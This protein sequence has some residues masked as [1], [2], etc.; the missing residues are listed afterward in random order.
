VNLSEALAYLDAHI[1]LEVLPQGDPGVAR[2]LDRMRSLVAALGDPQRAYPVLHLTGTNGKGSTARMLTTLLVARGLSVGTYTSPHLE[3]VNERLSWNDEAISDGAFAEVV[4]A[5]SLAERSLDD[6]PSYFELLTAAGFRWFDDIAVD[7]AVVEV[8]LGGRWDA[9]NVADAD[10]AVVTNVEMDHTEYLGPDRASIADVKA[11]IVKPGSRLVLGETDPDLAAP[12]LAAEPEE[13]WLRGR[14]FECVDNRLAHGGRL[15]VLRTP[16][17]FVHDIFLPLHG[18]H[19]GDN[20]AAALAASELFFGGPLAEEAVQEA[21]AA[22][23][24]PGRMEVVGRRPLVMLDGA[25]NPAGAKA[26]AAALDEAFGV[27]EG[28]IFVVGLLGGRAP[29]EMLTA[30]GVAG[31][32]LVVTCPPPSPRALPAGEVADAARALGTE[33]IAAPSVEA[34][35][36]R[37]LA[38]AAEED[39]VIV[40][41]SLYV[42]GAAR[43][44]LRKRFA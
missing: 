44:L 22:V 29:A 43:P 27:V 35:L 12:F 32:R 40:T 10:V 11:G 4:E 25:H 26:L 5:V 24:N 28:R 3:R 8:G 23:R 39:A 33:A 9:T 2:S 31:A 42:V 36:D 30:L 38:A 13:V 1:N 37:A 15:L 20:A 21:F 34:A 16:H 19:Q 7:A 18:A 14:E 17:G 41:G 6:A